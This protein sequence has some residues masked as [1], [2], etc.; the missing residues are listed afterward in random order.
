MVQWL[1]PPVW[2]WVVGS[3]VAG[4][5]AGGLIAVGCLVVAVTFLE[6][7][8]HSGTVSGTINMLFLILIIII[9]LE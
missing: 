6:A 9:S 7:S 8:F 3:L 5:S 1:V 4:L 2:L